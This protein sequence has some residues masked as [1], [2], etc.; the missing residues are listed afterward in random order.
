[1]PSLI[2]AIK[3]RVFQTMPSKRGDIEGVVKVLTSQVWGEKSL[4]EM[5][6]LFLCF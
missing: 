5:P 2:A 4:E 1:M 3:R 6:C